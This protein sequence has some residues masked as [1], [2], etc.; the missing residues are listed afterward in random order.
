M[1]AG[2]SGRAPG[3]AILLGEHFVVYGGHAIATPLEGFELEVSLTAGRVPGR[4]PR[5]RRSGLGVN[6]GSELGS[7]T[8]IPRAA[9]SPPAALL[10]VAR[11]LGVSL[12]AELEVE[13]SSTIPCS[14]GL[15]SSAALAV[16]CARAVA[17]LE[18]SRPDLQRIARAAARA[19][20]R[21]HGGRASG[22][23]VATVLAAGPLLFQRQDGEQRT[24]ELTAHSRVGIAL[25][26]S[27]QPGRTRDA[28]AAAAAW[29]HRNRQRFEE[30]LAC[31][32]ADVGSLAV[33][34]RRGDTAEL[35]RGFDRAHRRLVELGVS[36]PRLDRLVEE[37]R[38]AGACGAKLTGGGMG[39][40]VVAVL[41]IEAA[42]EFRCRMD[43]RGLLEVVGL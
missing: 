6:S 24:E 20:E 23:D 29:R 12:P 37:A 33:S 30:L 39:G 16:A 2:G 9:P 41:D 38:S 27:G 5:P 15:G 31:S 32:E 40:C 19:E 26:D 25:I 3:K 43:G 36:S 35:G 13:V 17:E 8:A 10:D 1:V 14:A 34:L 28:V 11:E 42:E 18:E 7:G 21:A 4:G 22:I